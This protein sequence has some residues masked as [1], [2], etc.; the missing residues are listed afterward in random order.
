MQTA[1][2]IIY[3]ITIVRK[4]NS[5]KTF[6]SLMPYNTVQYKIKDHSSKYKQ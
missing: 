1:M 6:F 4:N 3:I 2:E 5:E